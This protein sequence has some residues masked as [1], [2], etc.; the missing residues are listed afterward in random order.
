MKSVFGTCFTPLPIICTFTTF[1]L[2]EVYCGKGFSV[3]IPCL[4]P[5]KCE[6]IVQRV[7]KYIVFE[8]DH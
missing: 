6:W 4:G 8:I 7:N 2:G 1:L 5:A 3:E